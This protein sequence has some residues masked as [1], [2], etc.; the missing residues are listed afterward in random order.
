MKRYDIFISHSRKYGD[1]EIANLIYDKLAPYY[2]VYL[3]IRTQDLGRFDK[4]LEE[5][6]RN[7]TDF[8]LIISEDFFVRESWVWQEV[9]WALENKKN[10]IP[11]Y[12]DANNIYGRSFPEN[13]EDIAKLAWVEYHERRVDDVMRD[14]IKYLKTKSNIKR[15]IKYLS[16]WVCLI[17]FSFILEPMSHDSLIKDELRN[18]L[19]RYTGEY[20]LIS[21]F[22]CLFFK[23]YFKNLVIDTYN[24]L[25]IRNN[26]DSKKKQY[27]C[28]RYF[29]CR[30]SDKV[31][32]QYFIT[33]FE[34]YVIR[35]I[36]SFGLTII[37]WL[38]I[39]VLPM[40]ETN[41]LLHY[42]EA[43]YYG[44]FEPIYRKTICVILSVALMRLYIEIVFLRSFKYWNKNRKHIIIAG[45]GN[46]QYIEKNKEFIQWILHM[47]QEDTIFYLEKNTC[48]EECILCMLQNFFEYN[49]NMKL[50]DYIKISKR[51]NLECINMANTHKVCYIYFI[52]RDED[53]N[54]DNKVIENNTKD[55]RCLE[56][57][58]NILIFYSEEHILNDYL[59]NAVIKNIYQLS[60]ISQIMETEVFKTEVI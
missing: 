32:E 13:L 4:L 18:F 27:Y 45:D 36:M 58:E 54:S 50:E 12:I 17:I 55:I 39:F 30:K 1:N 46:I 38:S 22:L 56:N 24:Y 37:L 44:N 43:V 49:R 35:I 6:V 28:Y 3:D 7:C 47:C 2:S 29:Y 11:V 5:Y 19:S 31:D 23:Q 40:I 8:I 10:I 20:L 52:N 15:C 14:I 42:F 34:R 9:K 60:N 59:E 51:H 53:W 26:R 33:K 57:Y 41:L 16:A 21:F 48:L 25:F